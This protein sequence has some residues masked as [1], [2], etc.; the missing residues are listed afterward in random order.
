MPGSPCSPSSP[1]SP[2]SPCSSPAPLLALRTRRPREVLGRRVRM[3][4]ERPL[5]VLEQVDVG[6]GVDVDVALVA[7]AGLGSGSRPD[8]GRISSSAPRRRPRRRSRRRL[9]RRAARRESTIARAARGTRTTRTAIARPATRCASRASRSAGFVV[10]SARRDR[11]SAAPGGLAPLGACRRCGLPASG[12]WCPPHLAQPRGARRS[13]RVAAHAM[14]G[15]PSDRVGATRA[16]AGPAPRRRAGA[17][18]RQDEGP[19][20]R[21]ERPSCARARMPRARRA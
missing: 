5:A 12:S 6:V 3:F 2:C 14:G 19:H 8:P 1:C 13:A 4:D 9:R 18:P 10:G 11:R 21:E 16:V 20:R 17:G 15:G 7:L